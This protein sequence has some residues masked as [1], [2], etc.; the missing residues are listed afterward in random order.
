MIYKTFPAQLQNPCNTAEAWA[1]IDPI[2]FENE[3]GFESD[4]GY[5]KI[6]NGTSTWNE[7]PYSQSSINQLIPDN[8]ITI[9]HN[10]ISTELQYDVIEEH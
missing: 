8:G 2:L 4:T 10:Y 7:L 6:G 3:I 1:E 5:F 9:S